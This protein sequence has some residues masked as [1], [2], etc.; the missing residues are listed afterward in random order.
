MGLGAQ[1]ETHPSGSSLLRESSS[2][3]CSSSRLVVKSEHSIRQ[4]DALLQSMDAEDEETETERQ[5]ANGVGGSHDDDQSSAIDSDG[6][7]YDMTD[8]DASDPALFIEQLEEVAAGVH[9]TKTQLP[10]DTETR[11][12][13][14]TRALVLLTLFL[15]AAGAGALAF[16]LM[17]HKEDDDFDTSVGRF[18]IFFLVEFC[19]GKTCF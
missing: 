3:T 16:S 6:F 19:F 18:V 12:V 14:C 8:F 2:S 7:C 15:S 10:T 11:V 17:R 1:P 5:Q 4:T 13:W 9:T